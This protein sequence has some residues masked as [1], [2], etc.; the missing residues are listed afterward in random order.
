MSCIFIEDVAEAVEAI[1]G[2]RVFGASW[3]R[4]KVFVVAESKILKRP[5]KC[6]AHSRRSCCCCCCQGSSCRVSCCGSRSLG[7]LC[8]RNMVRRCI[9][10]RRGSRDPCCNGM[11]SAAAQMLSRCIAPNTTPGESAYQYYHAGLAA[12]A[13][14]VLC[15]FAL[16]SFRAAIVVLHLNAAALCSLVGL[17]RQPQ[18]SMT[19][20]L[21]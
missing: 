14:C 3:G 2:I 8:I 13:R 9:C 12:P 7:I 5:A 18:R 11:H 19:L 4:W 16:S 21:F 20:Q 10:C 17:H 15:T 6:P 1:N